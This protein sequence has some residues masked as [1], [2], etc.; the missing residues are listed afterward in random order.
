MNT[1]GD[2][3]TAEL[4]AGGDTKTGKFTIMIES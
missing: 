4:A 3:S 2:L 1:M